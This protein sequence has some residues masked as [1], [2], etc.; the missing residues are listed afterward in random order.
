MLVGTIGF[1]GVSLIRTYTCTEQF[2]A[3]FAKWRWRRAGE[4]GWQTVIFLSVVALGHIGLF[5]GLS[6]RCY[7]GRKSFYNSSF[8]IR[9]RASVLEYI[10]T[11]TDSDEDFSLPGPADV[12][13]VGR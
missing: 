9:V 13:S 6:L 2:M 3:D 10:D 8:T 7:H 4:A 1:L 5:W 11:R 12:D